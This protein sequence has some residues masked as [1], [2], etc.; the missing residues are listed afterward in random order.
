MNGPLWQTSRWQRQDTGSQTLHHLAIRI[1]GAEAR[2]KQGHPVRDPGSVSY[3]AA[4]ES[5][6]TADTSEVR[7][8]FEG[9]VLRE[10]SRRRFCGAKLTVDLEHRLRTVSQSHPDR[11]PISR[12]TTSQRPGQGSP[13]GQAFSG[14]TLG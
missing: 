4:I 6:A 5:A 2:V 13:F 3:S 11:G 8:K 12:Q 14:L 9:R 10:T 7:S 1:W